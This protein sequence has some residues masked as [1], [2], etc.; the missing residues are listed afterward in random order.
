MTKREITPAVDPQKTVSA[1]VRVGVPT[2]IP[3]LL[4]VPCFCSGFELAV[5]VVLVVEV[6]VVKGICIGGEE[7]VTAREE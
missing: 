2:A 1:F 4:L 5:V 7:E 3:P 6:V